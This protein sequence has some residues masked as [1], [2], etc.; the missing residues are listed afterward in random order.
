MSCSIDLHEKIG[1]M[2]EAY[3]YEYSFKS[4]NLHV[5]TNDLERKKIGK[6]LSIYVSNSL[7]TK[8]RDETKSKSRLRSQNRLALE[9]I[10]LW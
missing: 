4:T 8:N 5:K 2:L 7:I 1:F 6:Q 3:I 9:I 10:G